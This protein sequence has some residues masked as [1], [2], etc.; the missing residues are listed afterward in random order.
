MLEGAELRRALTD[1]SGDQESAQTAY[2]RDLFPGGARVA[3]G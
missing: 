2:E 1:N 3:E